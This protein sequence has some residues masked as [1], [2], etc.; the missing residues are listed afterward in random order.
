MSAH[1]MQKSRPHNSTTK[2]KSRR[3]KKHHLEQHVSTQPPLVCYLLLPLTA[4]YKPVTCFITFPKQ[5]TH[6]TVEEIEKHGSNA[7]CQKHS[8]LPLHKATPKRSFTLPSK[9]LKT[10][11]SFSF[12][13]FTRML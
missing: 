6:N 9:I 12:Q 10:L 1:L 7:H 3:H 4:E 13:P 2:E 8:T 5:N 11:L